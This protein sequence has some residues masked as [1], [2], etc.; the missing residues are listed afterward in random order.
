MK[1]SLKGNGNILITYAPAVNRF[2]TKKL[3]GFCIESARLICTQVTQLA[4]I[5][6]STDNKV[7]IEMVE[8]D[9]QIGHEK[10]DQEGSY[11]G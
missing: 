7:Q 5:I 11:T 6:A 1:D 8:E 3:Q 9:S 4:A 10:E 2:V